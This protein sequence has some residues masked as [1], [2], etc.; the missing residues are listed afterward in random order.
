MGNQYNGG[1]ELGESNQP[2]SPFAGFGNQQSIP[3]RLELEKQETN[4]TIPPP[5][6]PRQD[7]IVPPFVEATQE[8]KIH[9]EK[10]SLC[11]K[12]NEDAYFKTGFLGWRKAFSKVTRK[13]WTLKESNQIDGARF[14][15]VEDGKVLNILHNASDDMKVTFSFD[16]S[17]LKSSYYYRIVMVPSFNKVSTKLP[18]MEQD[19]NNPDF[20]RNA[21]YP[22]LVQKYKDP[23]ETLT[24]PIHELKLM[25]KLVVAVFKDEGCLNRTYSSTAMDKTFDIHMEKP[26][27]I[28]TTADDERRRLT[29]TPKL[30]SARARRLGWKPSQDMDW[31]PDYRQRRR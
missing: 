29:E 20:E 1:G 26:E 21:A 10:E 28:V 17:Q 31:S 19:P 9:M 7:T 24:I 11:K 22:K 18:E 14:V 23:Q 8:I 3:P 6:P 13:Y 12:R 2:D 4:Q 15:S 5:L 25:N 16:G 27:E 30:D